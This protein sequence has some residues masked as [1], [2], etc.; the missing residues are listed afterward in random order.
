MPIETGTR[1]GPYEI[2]SPLGAGGMGEVYRA[3]DT[4]LDRS[5]A[6]KVLSAHLSENPT[7]RQRFEREAKAL[8]SLQH[9][10]ICTLFDVGQE[11]G[12][13]F[14]VMEYLEGETLAARLE[15]GPLPAEQ[16]L[17]Y[18][19][20]I[21]DALDKAHR[22]GVVHR[23]LKPGNIM[24]TK[25]GAKLLDF[26]LAKAATNI[27]ASALSQYA[28][29]VSQSPTSPLTAEG[30]IVGTF[31]YMAPEQL[32]G[33]EAD[34]RSDIFSFGAVLYEMAT[35]RK[36]FP[37]KTQASAIAAIL[38]AEPPPITQLQPLTP[39]ALERVVRICLEKDADERWQT[40][41]DLKLQLQWIAEGGSLAGVPAPVVA[42]RKHWQLAGWAAA[43]VFALLAVVFAVGFVRRAPAPPRVLRA[44]LLPPEKAT[45]VHTVIS[46]DGTQLAF[47]ARAEGGK[48]MLWVRRLEALAAQP[49]PGTEGANFAFWSPDSRSIGFFA[50]G[51]LKKVEAAG[52]PPQTVCDAPEGRGGTWASDG[53]IL[54]APHPG[55]VIHRVPA[56]GGV[57]TPVTKFDQSRTDATHR[58]P[59]FLPDGQHFIYAV[60]GGAETTEE[61]ALNV[62]SL[63]GKV[64]KLLVHAWSKPAYASGY[65][66]FVR[67]GTLMAQRFDTSRLEMTGDAFPLAEQVQIN[68]G[69]GYASFSVSDNGVLAYRAGAPEAGSKLI[70]FDRAGK[71][72]SVLGD[73]AI[74]WTPRV[75]PDG[76]R[77]AVE[78][79]D[80]RIG[81]IDI[82]I[83]DVERGLRTRF[84]F[85][86]AP[87][88]Y[89]VWSP[90]GSRVVFNSNRKGVFNLFIK[91][92]SGAGTEELLYESKE[93]KWP[94]S[95][96]SDGK[97]LLF[98]N[99]GGKTRD[100][101]WAL[102]MTGEHK[103]FPV[104]QTPAEEAE[105]VISPDGRWLAYLSDESG[106]DEV[107]VAPFPGPGGKYQVS[108][109]GG[110]RPR[111]RRDGKELFYLGEDDKLMS[112]EIRVKGTS[113]EV[114]AVKPLF[115]TRPQR[116]GMIYDVS[117]DGQR[118]L[119]NSSVVE[120]VSSPV[121]LVLNWP[122][123]VA[124]K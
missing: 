28:P 85:D 4:R 48:E 7:L 24:L 9:P 10:H 102:T 61:S 72:L 108:V 113:L 46:P 71:E 37:G 97:F 93:N 35:G 45:F 65:L 33:R 77:V 20:E 27:V 29:T 11:H 75:S 38:T 13:D 34:A 87:E 25:A 105:P 86:A 103:A 73:Q 115:Q 119:V 117:G 112:A 8:S 84:T 16:V 1:L 67:E 68:V 88:F 57:A 80:P 41:H 26:G 104:V 74:Y 78:V 5:V 111:W 22:Q 79:S 40:A 83:Y 23:D 52:G 120:Q 54:F 31:H 56:A 21:A 110:E 99:E 51:K 109:N 63:D 66:L 32:E 15:K 60:R 18:G 95:W 96:S 116:L 69:N 39:P 50:N 44:T 49:L 123:G 106:K 70:F 6:I 90:D 91:D 2:L 121:T 89:P 43:A 30:T 36:A 3:R 92:S 12:V 62:E 118:F 14:L 98:E 64:K 76:R 107:Y 81:L 47:V 53:T 42:R 94:V 100:D 59:Y 17:R 55:T 101:L 122:T 58:W 124:K 82:W 19:I 114:G